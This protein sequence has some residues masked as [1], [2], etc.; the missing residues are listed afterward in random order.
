MDSA[1]DFHTHHLSTPPGRGI[2]NLPK[3]ILLQPHTFCP[4]EGALYSAGIHPWWTTGDVKSMMEGL[5]E[6]LPHP[7]IVAL[8]ECGFDRLQ[9]APMAVQEEVFVAQATLAEQYGLPMTLHCVRAFDR[10]LALHKLL[11]PTHRWTLHGF[12][13]KP[14]LACQLLEAGFDLSF[15]LHFHPD[16][17]R[18]VPAERRHTETDDAPCT[19]AEVCREQERALML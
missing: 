8:G 15:G 13:G 9:G 16:S 12:R 7:Q 10:L 2:V 14:Q 1:F 6:L 5:K 18:L 4:E 17:L 11:R 3:D 19:I